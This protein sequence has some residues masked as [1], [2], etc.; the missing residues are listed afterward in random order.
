MNEK[1][2]VQ[3]IELIFHLKFEYVMAGRSEE[4]RGG[5]KE[6]CCPNRK[7]GRKRLS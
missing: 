7:V 1:P 4:E 6:E 5:D 3:W 2:M